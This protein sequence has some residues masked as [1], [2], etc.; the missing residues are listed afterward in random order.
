MRLKINNDETNDLIL[1]I[2]TMGI[3]KTLR[4]HQSIVKKK[5]CSDFNQKIEM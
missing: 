4:I 3:A 1:T 5:N 2:F